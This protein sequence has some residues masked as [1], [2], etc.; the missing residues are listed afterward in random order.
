MSRY[1]EKARMLRATVTPHYNCAQSVLLP[2]AADAGIDEATALRFADGFG[3]GMKRGSVCGVYTGGAMVL[4]LFGL[5]NPQTMG[6]YARRIREAHGG[7]TDCADLLRTEVGPGQN[8]KPH[9]D[10]MV[11]EAVAALEEILREKGRLPE[12]A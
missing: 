12:E 4:G 11:F 7:L 3:M 8:R 1:M 2:F 5:G 6:E 9:C 10:A